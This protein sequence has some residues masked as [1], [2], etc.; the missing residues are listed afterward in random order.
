MH[1]NSPKHNCFKTKLIFSQ[2]WLNICSKNIF[3]FRS[4]KDTES[5]KHHKVLNYDKR[6]CRLQ[7]PKVQKVT[8]G[9]GPSTRHKLEP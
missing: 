6:R 8:Q 1:D 9:Q 4:V 5:T 7:N 2:T 3:G